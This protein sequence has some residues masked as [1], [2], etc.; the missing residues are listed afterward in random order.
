[1]KVVVIQE[2]GAEVID[3]VAYNSKFMSVV[4]DLLIKYNYLSEKTRIYIEEFDKYI[5]TREYYGDDWKERMG[6]MS[7]EEFN[8]IFDEDE[9]Y[10]E[11]FNVEGMTD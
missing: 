1:M 2:V 5:P 3:V 4:I 11:V 6:K 9:M 10:L 7:I 8:R